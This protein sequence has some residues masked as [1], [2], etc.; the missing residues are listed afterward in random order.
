MKTNGDAARG[1]GAKF[2]V[3]GELEEV[4]RGES[5]RASACLASSCYPEPDERRRAINKKNRAMAMRAVCVNG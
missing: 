4:Q 5:Q 2:G 1:G 3:R